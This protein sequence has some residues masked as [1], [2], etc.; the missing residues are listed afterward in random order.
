ME[1]K[2]VD[3]GPI[4][5][6]LFRGPLMRRKP[7]TEKYPWVRM[8]CPNKPILLYNPF[9]QTKLSCVN[10]IPYSNFGEIMAKN[11]GKNHGKKNTVTSPK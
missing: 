7:Y 5:P 10:D 8:I 2:H 1:Q 9:T 3:P 4:V 6:F 11:N